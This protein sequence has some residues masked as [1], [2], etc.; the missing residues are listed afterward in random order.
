M[1]DRLRGELGLI[2]L[3]GKDIYER[4]EELR[5]WADSALAELARLRGAQAWQ[6]IETAPKWRDILI[7]RDDGSVDFIEANDNGYGFVPYEKQK[8]CA[9]PT[10]WMPLPEAPKETEK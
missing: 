5:L 6:P 2:D 1:S 4:Y 3:P 9:S 8:W 10:H 7:A